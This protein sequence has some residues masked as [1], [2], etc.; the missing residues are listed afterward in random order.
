V[1]GER[2][3][4][5]DGKALP[6]KSSS[7][8]KEIASHLPGTANEKLHRSAALPA[9]MNLTLQD[10]NHPIGRSAFLK[11]NLARIANNFLAMAR[12]PQPV[13]KT[14]S[15]QRDDTFDGAA[16]SSTGWETQVR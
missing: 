11:Q 14:Q 9:H 8:K 4:R 13:F 16:I 2:P 15:M 12:Q 3:N 10:K 1:D 6:P 7:V 5:G